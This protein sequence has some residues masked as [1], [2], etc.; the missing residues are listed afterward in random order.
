MTQQMKH[1][2]VILFA[3]L[4]VTAI[5]GS[6]YKVVTKSVAGK[7]VE[8]ING[9]PQDVDSAKLKQRA[10]SGDADAQSSLAMCF[11]DGKH[12]VS[13]NYVEAYKWAILAASQNQKVAKHLVREM[14]LFI[15]RNDLAEGRTAAKAFL[16]NQNRTKH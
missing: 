8:V 3:C 14:E 5:A 16:E 11:Y 9:I 7:S 12:G 2:T 1:I 10:E 15:A 6:S 13:A 4:S